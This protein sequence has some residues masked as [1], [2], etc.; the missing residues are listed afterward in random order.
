MGFKIL[1]IN[2]ILIMNALRSN[3]IDFYWFF[4]G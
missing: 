1:K 2:F 4:M 3:F